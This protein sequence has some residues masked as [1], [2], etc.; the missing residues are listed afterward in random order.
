MTED[1][2]TEFAQPDDIRAALDAA[3]RAAVPDDEPIPGWRPPAHQPRRWSPSPRVVPL[4]AAAVVALAVGIIATVVAVGRSRHE[5]PIA[6]PPVTS[7]TTTVT[8]PTTASASSDGNATTSATA[9]SVPTTGAGSAAPTTVTT[10]TSTVSVPPFDLGYQPLWPFPDRGSAVAWEQQAPGGS[11][12]WHLDAGA[13]A[14]AFTRNYLGF[15]ELDLVTST[16]P[17]GA[18]VYVGVGYL[19]PNGMPQTAAVLHLARFGLSD[20]SPWEV[21]G[22]RDS[23][24]TLDQPGYGSVG[25]SPLTVGGLLTGVDESLHV[26]VRQ[27]SS[28]APIGENCCTSAGGAGSP[29][30][31]SVSYAGASDQVLTVAVSTGGHVQQVERFAITGVRTTG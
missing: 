28:T 16:E 7:V 23:T 4:L 22:S 3:A 15:T 24:L 20:A 18:E 1:L 27:L 11:A 10:T 17:A 21:V 25:T 13:T 29:W 2:R 30:R 12:P 19:N 31:V 14:L 6:P 26:T 5:R 8:S 9:T